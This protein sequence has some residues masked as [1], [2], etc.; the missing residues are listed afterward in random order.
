[1]EH[2]TIEVDSN[3]RS[4]ASD[5]ES[6]VSD[7][8]SVSSSIFDYVFENG[9][10]Y[11]SYRAGQYLLPN[12]ES[13]QDR[14]DLQ[15]HIFRLTLAG[16]ITATKLEDPQRILDVGTGTGIWAIDA[17][18][19]YPSAEVIGVDLSP[20]QPQWAPPNV[21]FEI[22]D[23]TQP[24][25]FEQNSF[26]FIHVRTLGGSIRDWVTFLKEAQKHLKPG[27]R[28]EI[29]EIRTRFHCDDGS[30][31]EDTSSIKF[32][33]TFHEIAEKIGIDFDPMLNMRGWLNE[34]GYEEIQE[35]EK[36]IPIGTWPKDK[37]LKGIGMY[38]QVHY[39]TG[40]ENYSMALFTRNG[41]KQEEVQVLIAQVRSESLSNKFHAYTKA[42]FLSGRKPLEA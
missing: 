42:A 7:T 40:I 34:A 5:Y 38:Y 10:S 18:D 16:E 12:D 20:I 9:H 32:E 22:D 41:W 29:S 15:H 23:L 11:H 31:S 1:M 25:T 36:L 21:K 39:L 19:I 33:R 27:G 13:E 17:G 8:T 14:L 30:L 24:W 37:K 6:V 26:D 3:P 2:H 35:T 4:S 28:I